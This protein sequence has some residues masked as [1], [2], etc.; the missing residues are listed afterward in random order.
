M[1]PAE[2]SPPPNRPKPRPAGQPLLTDEAR[3]RRLG[4]AFSDAQDLAQAREYDAL[5]P[6]YPQDAVDRLLSTSGEYPTVVELGAGSGILT[7]DLLTHPRLH[8]GVLHAVEPSGP[9]LEILGETQDPRLRLHRATAEQT[10]LP[11]SCADVVVASQ[12][13]HWF[14]PQQTQQELLRIL[15]PGATVAVIANYLDTSH[16]WV[17]RLT[18][19]MRAGD[20]YRPQWQPQFDAGSSAPG[21]VTP[22]SFS[23][24]VSSVFTHARSITP[25]EILRLAT[26]LSS[27]LSAPE[28]DRARRRDNLQWYLYEHLGH[29]EGEE[30]SLP[31]LTALHTSGFSRGGVSPG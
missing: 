16:P 24:V 30:L 23:P 17:H 28:K 18:R 3:R 1:R 14:D 10:G 2:S 8:G 6:R 25:E 4:S 12:S 27:W 26:T 21:S 15:R 19:I 11:A 20:V 22:R 13:W 9:M 7:R 31:Y 29:R 5:R